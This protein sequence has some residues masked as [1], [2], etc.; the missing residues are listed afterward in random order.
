M[1]PVIQLS[2]LQSYNVN[3]IDTFRGKKRKTL[4]AHFHKQ[5][6]PFKT[7][8]KRSFPLAFSTS[9]PHRSPKTNPPKWTPSAPPAP[10]VQ[11]PAQ[12]PPTRLSTPSLTPVLMPSHTPQQRPISAAP[13]NRHG[14][15][16]GTGTRALTDIDASITGSTDLSGDKKDRINHHKVQDLDAVEVDYILGKKLGQ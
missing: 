15:G 8:L 6:G 4:S 7:S 12:P 11:Q 14:G 13:R 2:T 1:H 3:C 5:L 10:S 9:K 16:S